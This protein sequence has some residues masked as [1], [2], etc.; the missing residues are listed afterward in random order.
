MSRR[1]APLLGALVILSSLAVTAVQAGDK[2]AAAASPFVSVLEL[3]RSKQ[4]I[5]DAEAKSLSLRG[6]NAAEAKTLVEL[7]QAKGLISAEDAAKIAALPTQEALGEKVL[8]ASQDAKFIAQL[9]ERWV[10][11]KNRG[12]DFDEWFAGVSDPEEIIGRMRVM[13]AVSG[14]EADELEAWYRDHYLTGAISAALQTKEQDYLERVRKG[15]AWELDEKIKEKFKGE[16]SQ[17]VRLSGDFRLR[18]ESDFFDGQNATGLGQPSN[19]SQ[20]LNSTID[21]QALKLRARLMVDAKVADDFQVGIG[22]ATDTNRSPGSP[23]STNATLGDSFNK[24]A[25]ALDKA[26]LKWS[27]APSFDVWGG[28]FAN[29][30]LS[31]DLVWDPDVNF[32][33]VAF[34]FRPQLSDKWGLFLSAG[35]FPVQEVELSSHDKWLFGSQLGVQYKSIDNLTARLGAAFYDF[36]NSVGVANSSSLST[37]TDWSAPLF[38]QKGNTLM[39]ITGPGGSGRKFAYASDFRELNLTGSLDL[40]YWEP[41]HLILWADYVNN[42]GFSGS[43]V[44]ARVGVEVKKETEGFQAGFTVGY[45][46]VQDFG[47][48]QALFFYKY[49]ERDAVMDAFADSD[50]H[51]GGTNA[52]GWITGADFGVS[53]NVWLSTRWF[54][55]NEISGDRLSI[56]VFHFNVNARF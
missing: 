49:L 33:G 26:F 19:P 24:K 34:Q 36:T 29:P 38:Q 37:T 11:N 52:K 17:R 27:P 32:D 54:S 13:G 28:R 42:L 4:I 20:V 51:L 15:V 5:S 10:K 8:P 18:Y 14:A 23:V 35:A 3:L 43:K 2:P 6:G 55:A 31:T 47:E 22:I 40:G 39:D 9:R 46:R 1:L 41:A 16:W 50:F 25:L 12:R 48:W 56:D 21:R 44:S 7:L 45:P 53:K 30:W